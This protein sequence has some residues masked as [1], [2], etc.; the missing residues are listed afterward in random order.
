MKS[1]LSNMIYLVFFLLMITAVPVLTLLNN[2]GNRDQFALESEVNLSLLNGSYSKVAE[3]YFDKHLSIHEF[4]VSTM[5]AVQY[6]FF[7]EGADGVVVG[8]NQWLFSNEEFDIPANAEENL[9]TN[10]ATISSIDSHLKNLNI[11]L[12]VVPIPAKARILENQLANRWSLTRENTYSRMIEGLNKTDV[13][14]VDSYSAMYLSSENLFFR[15]DTHWTPAG[16]KIVAQA[17]ADYCGLK[18]DLVLSVTDYSTEVLES[19]ELEGDLMS[20]IPL[21]PWFSQWGPSIE[22]FDLQQTYESSSS[23]FSAREVN[24]VLV[25]TSY[26]ADERWNFPGFLKQALGRDLV[27]YSARGLGPYRPMYD[28]LMD[29]D[30]LSGVD[31]IVWEIPERYLMRSYSELKFSQVLQSHRNLELSAANSVQNEI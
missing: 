21:A 28:L 19:S 12:V 31:L 8:R 26:S 17:T 23:L 24:T 11:A 10:L 3:D 2:T 7:L 22:Y 9:E 15:S 1:R 20:Y 27:N 5:A 18:T 29:A 13:H 25:G 6:F 4:A 14:V 16:A 30:A